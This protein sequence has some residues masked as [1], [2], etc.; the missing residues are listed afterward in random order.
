MKFLRLGIMLIIASTLLFLFNRKWHEQEESSQVT[1]SSNEEAMPDKAK[2]L[3]H[4]KAFQDTEKMVEPKFVWQKLEH[5]QEIDHFKPEKVHIA[6]ISLTEQ[7]EFFHPEIGDK[8][9]LPLPAYGHLEITVNNVYRS[10]DRV[11]YWTANLSSNDSDMSNVVATIDPETS[12]ASMFTDKGEYEMHLVHGKGWVYRLTPIEMTTDDV[13][14]IPEDTET[15]KSVDT[16]Q[17][18][19]LNK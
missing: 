10:S 18:G 6:A 1:Q 15:P 14:S 3:G 7:Q 2:R 17:S 11:E 13:L 12:F 4:G 19:V 16:D 5:T 8:F 9:I